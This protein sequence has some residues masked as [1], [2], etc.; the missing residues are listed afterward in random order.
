MNCG[1]LL[2]GGIRRVFSARLFPFGWPCFPLLLLPPLLLLLL[3][4]GRQRVTGTIVLSRSLDATHTTAGNTSAQF[5]GSSSSRVLVGLGA[6][7]HT[8]A[9]SCLLCRYPVSSQSNRGWVDGRGDGGS[10]M[11]G[12]AGSNSP[13]SRRMI[14]C[15]PR[16]LPVSVDSRCTLGACRQSWQGLQYLRPTQHHQPQYSRRLW[17]VGGSRPESICRVDR[18]PTDRVHA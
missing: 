11:G 6:G 13:S 17:S 4:A 8:L 1:P 9:N 3:P 18:T 7:A 10:S 12:E 14:V 15:D 2:T 16:F 5:S